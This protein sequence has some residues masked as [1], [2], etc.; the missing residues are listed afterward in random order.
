MLLRLTSLLG[1]LVLLA[2]A[3]ALS[4]DRRRF[5]W[6][7]VLWGLGL[8]A[9]FAL[10]I[11]RTGFGQRIFGGAQQVLDQLNVYAREGAKM[12]FG[13][14][15]N[16]ETLATAFGPTNA[17][18]FAV[19]ISATIIFISA[20]SS[21]LYHW[22]ILQRVVQGMAWVMRRAMRTSGTESLGAAANIFL[23]PT[24][25]AL[26]VKPYLAKMS[27][28]EL[29]ALMVTGM[30][31][32]ASGVMAVYAGMGVPAG[33]L[34]TAS[35]LAAPAGLLISKIMLPEDPARLAG[36]AAQGAETVPDESVNGLDAICRGAT[37]GVTLSLGVLGML[38]AFV[39]LVAM[40]NALFG[41]VQGL[42]GVAGPFT[43]QQVLGWVNAPF[44]WLIGVPVQDCAA[45]GQTL[46]ERVV[47][48]E[49]VGYLSLAKQHEQGLLQERSFV[50][51]SY[52]LC[53]F[54]NFGSIAIT[55]AGIG[56][57]VPER[58]SELARLGFRSMIG[59]LLACYLV[60]ALVG[61]ML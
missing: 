27:T 21:L 54:A 38:I 6:R 10:L 47:L 44:A 14:L 20:L 22:G 60:A 46:G 19:T 45:V 25:A 24:E 1:V 13:P 56:A 57:L 9:V 42:F 37:E 35:V 34:L 2:A 52:A 51:A 30:S 50:L 48:N 29:L 18:V 40:T 53:G 43:L 7:T 5:P 3:W 16:G 59:G 41:W 4:S 15:A 39:A 12:V 33:H 61:V 55:I 31:T 36:G 26:L 11:L 28:S 49:F 32:I 8:Q 17:F 58:R 23:G